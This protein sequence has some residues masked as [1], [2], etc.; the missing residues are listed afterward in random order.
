MS[1]T[2]RFFSAT[3][4]PGRLLVLGLARGGP[5]NAARLEW[6]HEPEV[7]VLMNPRAGDRKVV[8]KDE[9]EAIVM[10]P[11]ARTRFLWIHEILVE[12]ARRLWERANEETA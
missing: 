5:W 8:T 4:I 12:D 2:D 10:A 9:L 1:S 11:T 3:V 6:R 7:D